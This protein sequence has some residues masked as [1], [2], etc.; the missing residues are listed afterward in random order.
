MRVILCLA[1]CVAVLTAVGIIHFRKSGD[2]VDVSIDTGE[3]R[4]KTEELIDA[5]KDTLSDDREDSVSERFDDLMND[6]RGAVDA[7]EETGTE[8]LTHPRR[9]R[10]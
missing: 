9:P 6:A 2:R 8:L 10:R 1:L 7:T 3:L 4:E 5:V